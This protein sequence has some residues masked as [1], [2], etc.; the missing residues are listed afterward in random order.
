MVVLSARPFP[1]SYPAASDHVILITAR[2]PVRVWMFPPP[3]EDF[4]SGE[5]LDPTLPAHTCGEITYTLSIAASNVHSTLDDLPL[6]PS[7]GGA[8]EAE[9]FPL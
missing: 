5:G 1:P 8:D 3:T 7:S 2:D 4:V 6:F 9:E